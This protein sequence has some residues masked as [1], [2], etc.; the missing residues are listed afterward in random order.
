MLTPQTSEPATR[1]VVP[2]QTQLGEAHMKVIYM[3][4]ILN[5]LLPIVVILAGLGVRHFV[6]GG[7]AGPVTDQT[8]IMFYALLFVAVSE[9]GVT[10]FLKKLFLKPLPTTGEPSESIPTIAFIQSRYL[11]LYNLA[12]APAIYGF[13]WYFLGGE[14]KEFVL[15][16][17]ISLIMF[18]LVRPSADFFYS[19]FG[20]RP[21]VE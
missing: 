13:V 8:R 19:L 16:A 2:N 6:Q 12:F 11:I 9:I 20:A 10:I 3:G 18:R 4:L 15:F 5:M 21:A 17:V 1:T 7:E 14:L